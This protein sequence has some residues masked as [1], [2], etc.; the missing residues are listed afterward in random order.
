MFQF[1]PTLPFAAKVN[2]QIMSDQRISFGAQ[3]N[4]V[5]QSYPSDQ[6]AGTICPG[7]TLPYNDLTNCQQDIAAYYFELENAEAPG[8]PGLPPDFQL[9]L[10]ANAGP[11][12]VWNLSYNGW[13]MDPSKSISPLLKIVTGPILNTGSVVSV[14]VAA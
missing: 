5:R 1:P 6:L 11:S 4:Q 3:Y 9:I 12:E 13:G 2:P 8:N 7:T 14:L 10:T